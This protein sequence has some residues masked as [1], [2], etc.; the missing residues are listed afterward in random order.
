MEIFFQFFQ[1][2]S[3]RWNRVLSARDIFSSGVCG[4][5]TFFFFSLLT[6]PQAALERTMEQSLSGMASLTNKNKDEL[7]RLAG[8]IRVSLG[9]YSTFKVWGR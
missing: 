6:C 4:N 5:H 8:V 3:T 7:V 1:G 9:L 2:F